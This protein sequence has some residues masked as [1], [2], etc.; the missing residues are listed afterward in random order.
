MKKSTF[1]FATLLGASF[2]LGCS[3]SG[4][5]ASA[6]GTQTCGKDKTVITLTCNFDLCEKYEAYR[7]DGNNSLLMQTS[8]FAF[9][10]RFKDQMLNEGC[11][12]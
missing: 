8:P 7:K 10:G 11:T 9:V 2:L 3:D 5:T 12:E 1:L 4:T 6:S